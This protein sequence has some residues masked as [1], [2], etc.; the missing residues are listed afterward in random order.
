[1]LSTAGGH[2]ADAVALFAMAAKM[3][4]YFRDYQYNLAAMMYESKQTTEMI[5]VVHKLVALDP[6]NPENIML[7]AFAFKGLSD[8]RRT[9]RRRRR[10]SIR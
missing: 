10:R 1:M 3:N 8:T 4:P 9:P 2:T 7:F 6:S 5:P